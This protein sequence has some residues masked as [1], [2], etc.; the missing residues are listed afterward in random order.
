MMTTHLSDKTSMRIQICCETM[1]YGGVLFALQDLGT[2][3]LSLASYSQLFWLVVVPIAFLIRSLVSL[4]RY[5]KK[6]KA[7]EVELAVLKSYIHDINPDYVE[8]MEF[9]KYFDEA[10]E[11]DQKVKF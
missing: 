9:G 7:L 5:V 3:L 11:A 4:Y 10:I 1:I 2:H 8:E 6:S